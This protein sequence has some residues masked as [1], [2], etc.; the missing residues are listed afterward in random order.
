M[1]WSNK[2]S[3]VTEVVHGDKPY[4][5]YWEEIPDRPSAYHHLTRNEDGTFAAWVP[6]ERAAT[7]TPIDSQIVAIEREQM[8]P[9]FVREGFLGVIL[10]L[11]MNANPDLTQMQALSNLTNEAHQ[12]YNVGFT[13]LLALD[14]QIR[15]LRAQRL[16]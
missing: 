3:S 2:H 14:N 16:P 11:Y 9:R 10:K 15:A 8:A 6:D 1:A 4:G 13:R 7:N 5:N 12:D